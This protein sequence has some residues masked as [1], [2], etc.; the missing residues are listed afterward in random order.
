MPACYDPKMPAGAAAHDG[1]MPKNEPAGAVGEGVVSTSGR[2]LKGMP[3]A[4]RPARLR[5]AQSQLQLSEHRESRPLRVTEA[6]DVAT[7][8][9]E[10]LPRGERESRVVT[11]EYPMVERHFH[12]FDEIVPHEG[13]DDVVYRLRYQPAGEIRVGLDLLVDHRNLA[14]AKPAAAANSGMARCRGLRR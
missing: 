10:A 7:L 11:G 5:S 9:R 13:I 1:T 8:G 4:R 6:L 14:E 3:A 2:A 12:A